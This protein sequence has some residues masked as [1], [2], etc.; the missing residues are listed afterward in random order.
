MKKSDYLPAIK[1]LLELVDTKALGRDDLKHVNVVRNFVESK[2]TH[3][4]SP[5]NLSRKNG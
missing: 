1:R 4:P 5:V 2:E 3:E